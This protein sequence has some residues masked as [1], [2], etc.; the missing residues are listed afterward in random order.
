MRKKNNIYIQFLFVV[1]T[2]L[3]KSRKQKCLQKPKLPMNI[4]HL[5]TSL[6]IAHHEFN[7]N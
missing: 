6:Q 5:L 4:L 3:G 2:T 7:N 1:L